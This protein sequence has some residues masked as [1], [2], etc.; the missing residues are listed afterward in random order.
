LGV[1]CLLIHRVSICLVMA[2]LGTCGAWLMSLA[3][4]TRL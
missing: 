3:G 1:F 2:D 4:R